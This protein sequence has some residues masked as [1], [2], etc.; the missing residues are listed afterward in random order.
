VNGSAAGI[1]LYL[2]REALMLDGALRPVRWTGFVQAAQKYQGE[3][4]GKAD[5]LAAFLQKID[6]VKT[7]EEARAVFPELEQVW[8]SIFDLVEKQ[9]GD[10]YLYR[11]EQLMRAHM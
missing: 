10:Q 7:P 3:V 9:A 5:V 4:E 2:G 1:E 8:Q 6:A 11:Y